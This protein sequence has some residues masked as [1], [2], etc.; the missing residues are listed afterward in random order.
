MKFKFCPEC[1]YKLDGEYKFCPECGYKLL[2]NLDVVDTLNK[3]EVNKPSVSDFDD[4]DLEGAFDNQINE[5]ESKSKVYT[6]KHKKALNYIIKGEYDKAIIEYELLMD[7][8]FND[9]N[10]YIG[11][12]RAKSR[13]YTAF[14]DDSLKTEIKAAVDIFT[15]KEL[16]K[17]ELLAKYFEKRT[18]YLKKKKED[19]K[20]A[21][22]KAKQKEKDDYFNKI[23]FHYVD[24][25]KEFVTFGSYYK[26]YTSVSYL[27]YIPGSR[28]KLR[29][30]SAQKV[31]YTADNRR[32][33]Y[34]KGNDSYVYI[35]EPIYWRVLERQADRIFLFMCEVVPDTSGKEFFDNAFNWE[36]KYLIRETYREKYF[37]SVFPLKKYEYQKYKTKID[38]SYSDL[39]KHGI[40]LQSYYDSVWLLEYDSVNQDYYV[41]N[42]KQCTYNYNNH[43][44][45]FKHSRFGLWID[46]TKIK[47]FP[48]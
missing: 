43:Y 22:I 16:K 10:A 6:T 28:E 44:F 37:A 24:K 17:D 13:N 21:K 4:F 34:Q 46:L 39:T 2:N 7:E 40:Y 8:D 47:V 19:E 11:M 33:K 12:I 15:L 36:Q 18:E 41:Y 1:G 38:S 26:K 35:E 14:E 45:K 32:A 29:Y 3:E 23:G 5:F 25:N 20:L 30:D 42:N 31:F 9:I 27:P 48:D